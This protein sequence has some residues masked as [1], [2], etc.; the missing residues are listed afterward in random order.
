[1][2]THIAICHVSFA[3]SI[4][5]FLEVAIA[6]PCWKKEKNISSNV[7]WATEILW[8]KVIPSVKDRI[9]EENMLV[10]LFKYTLLFAGFL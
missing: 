1:M 7:I 5:T 8:W 9:Y 10:L 6:M 2:C 4:W 3:K